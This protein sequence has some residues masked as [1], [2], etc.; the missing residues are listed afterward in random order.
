MH[1][2]LLGTTRRERAATTIQAMARGVVGREL[3]SDERNRQAR[4][5]ELLLNSLRRLGTPVLLQWYTAAHDIRRV[6]GRKWVGLA[7]YFIPPA[8]MFMPFNA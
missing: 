3:V 1:N 5:S 8:F 7:M 2:P 4:I 6:R